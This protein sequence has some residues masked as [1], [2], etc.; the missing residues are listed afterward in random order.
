MTKLFADTV[1]QLTTSRRGRHGALLSLRKNHRFNSR[2]HEEVDRSTRTLESISWKVSTHDLTKRSTYTFRNPLSFHGVSTHDLTKRST[3]DYKIKTSEKYVSTHDLTKRSTTLD[4]ISVGFHP[5]V[6]THDLTKR[7]TLPTKLRCLILQM[8]QLTTSR[9]GRRC[10][11]NHLQR[12]PCVSTHDLTK[13]STK[14][15]LVCL[16]QLHVSTHDLTKR[17]TR[18]DPTVVLFQMAFQLTTSRRGRLLKRC[19]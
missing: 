4:K 17:S 2:P 10:K 6:S 1:F 7:S 14:S 9:R 18:V 16:I 15:N 13:R 3:V 19:G 5:L 12:I 8:F 11:A